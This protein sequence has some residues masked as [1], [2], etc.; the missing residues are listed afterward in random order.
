MTSQ[1]PRDSFR[2]DLSSED[3]VPES[4]ADWSSAMA[5][6]DKASRPPCPPVPVEPLTPL[7]RTSP[8]QP[9]PAAAVSMPTPAPD[10]T[11]ARPLTRY[12]QLCRQRSVSIE[13]NDVEIMTELSEIISHVNEIARLIER[14]DKEYNGY[15]PQRFVDMWSQ[16]LKETSM[17]MLKE[18]HALR[19]G[20]QQKKYDRR[21]VCCCC[22]SVFMVALPADGLC[23]ECRAYK[24]TKGSKRVLPPKQGEETPAPPDCGCGT[25][26]P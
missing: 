17:V 24:T 21:N 4:A 16:N 5:D 1:P 9:V 15:V 23:D 13:S 7:P 2:L 3:C 25:E 22:H 20:Q 18:F 19:N 12:E 14:L 10:C 11:P 6:L 26:N 8:A